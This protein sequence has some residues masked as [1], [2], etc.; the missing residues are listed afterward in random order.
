MV[1]PFPPRRLTGADDANGALPVGVNDHQEF[2]LRRFA[3]RN[4]ALFLLGV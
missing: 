3:Y 4:E 1:S 2:T